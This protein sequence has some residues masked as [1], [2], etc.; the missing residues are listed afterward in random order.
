MAP[1][2]K[3][4]PPTSHAP[5][6]GGMITYRKPGETTKYA[7]IEFLFPDGTMRVRPERGSRQMIDASDVARAAKLAR[8]LAA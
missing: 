5:R 6:T 7:L 3:R 8:K 2:Y 1:P 4:I